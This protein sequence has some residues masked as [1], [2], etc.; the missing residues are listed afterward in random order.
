MKIIIDTCD[1]LWFVS[2]DSKLSLSR[3]EAIRSSENTVFLSSVSAAEIAIKVSIKKLDLPESP[4]FYVPN[5][6]RLHRIAELPLDERAASLV[7][8]LPLHHKDPFDR[9]LVCQAIAG[10]FTLL[11][12][13]PLIHLYPVSLF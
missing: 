3:K 1:F 5:C 4:E 7:A 10:G 8:S 9:L 6:R 11:S 2:G 12:S 13:D